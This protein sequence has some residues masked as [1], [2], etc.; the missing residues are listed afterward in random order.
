LI[1]PVLNPSRTSVTQPWNLD[2]ISVSLHLGAGEEAQTDERAGEVKE[3][4]HRGSV[5]VV[6]DRQL[7]ERHEPRLGPLGRRLP[8]GAAALVLASIV[9]CNAAQP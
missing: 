9:A 1:A 5:A 3:G 7:P 2:L 8:A 4:E 6:A